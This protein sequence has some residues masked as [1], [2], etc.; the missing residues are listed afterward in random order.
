MSD[1]KN[2]N[3]AAHNRHKH[4]TKKHK[5]ATAERTRIEGDV[6]RLTSDLTTAQANADEACRQQH[7]EEERLTAQRTL[8]AQVK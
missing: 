3:E 4:T 7:D 2:A 8:L 6:A 1:A 5:D